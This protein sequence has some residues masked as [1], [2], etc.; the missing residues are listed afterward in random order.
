MEP[1]E[2]EATLRPNL[3][4]ATRLELREATWQNW[5]EAT[6]R[7]SVAGLFTWRP[8]LRVE[9]TWRPGVEGRP[10][11]RPRLMEEANRRP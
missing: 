9:A 6:L 2:G 3:V 7:P 5:V 8:D 10:I 4:E 11:Q 1:L